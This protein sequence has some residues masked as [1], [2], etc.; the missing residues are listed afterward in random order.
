MKVSAQDIRR[1]KAMGCLHNRE[2]EDEFSVRVVTGNGTLTN[3][4]MQNLAY[5][6]S[7]YGSGKVA[8]TARMTVEIVGVKYEDIPALQEHLAQAGLSS[9]G[10]GDKVRPVV[11]CKG[12]TCVFGQLDTQAVAR[13]IHE[14][15]YLGWREIKLPHKFKIAVGG[16]PN[17]CAKPD[18]NDFGLVGQNVPAKKA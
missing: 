9:G 8:L 3:A 11:A 4:Q 6:A 16:C 1:V 10:T 5:A 17:N 2:S 12:T 13:Q 7:R 14:R 18:L 15:F